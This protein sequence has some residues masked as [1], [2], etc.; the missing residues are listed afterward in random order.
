MATSVTLSVSRLTHLSGEGATKAYCDLTIA[1]TL[2][3]KGLSVIKGKRGL[4]VNM[5]RER[6]KDG[7]WYD[8]VI[9]ITR[10]A[11]QQITETVLAAYRQAP[12]VPD[13]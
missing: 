12:I 5:P 1:N 4:F 10:E 8:A 6:G 7:Q 2:V 11:R 9:P 13:A 3:V